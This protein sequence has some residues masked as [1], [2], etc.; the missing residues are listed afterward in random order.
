M[1][2]FLFCAHKRRAGGAPDNLVE[3]ARWVELHC[4]GG[5]PGLSLTIGSPGLPLYLPYILY[6]YILGECPCVVTETYNTTITYIQNVCYTVM[7]KRFHNPFV[8]LAIHKL[9][10]LNLVVSSGGPEGGAE[11]PPPQAPNY[12]GPRT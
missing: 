11:G 1:H 8:I 7:R 9:Y 4:R 2:A 3:S 6:I 12:I 10:Y 5:R